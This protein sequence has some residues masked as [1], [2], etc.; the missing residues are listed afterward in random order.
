MRCRDAGEIADRVNAEGVGVVAGVILQGADVVFRGW[1]AVAEA[2]AGAFVD[3]VLEG[4][5]NGAAGCLCGVDGDVGAVAAD[6][7]G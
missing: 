2:D 1:I 5:N 6:G 7:K 4:E 3:D